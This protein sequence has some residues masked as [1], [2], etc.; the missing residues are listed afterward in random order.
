MTIKVSTV[1]VSYNRLDLLHRAIQSA[2]AQTLP[3]CEVIVV[4][5]CSSF[6]VYEAMARYGSA[7]QVV[8]TPHNAGC[9]FARN[10]GIDHAT[11]E[12]V[13]FLDD[14]DYWRP[15]K[16]EHQVAV[17][18][19]RVMMLCGQEFTPVRKYNVQP[20]SQVTRE[21]IG[22]NN[23]LCGASGFLCR[24]DLLNTIRF[25]A[26]LIWGED[27]DL[28]LR[29]LAVG[30]IGYVAEPLVFYTVNTTGT[31]L[32]S[33]TRNRSWQEIQYR[34]A[35]A[36]KHR[37]EIGEWNYRQRVADTILAH[38]MERP[39]RLSFIGHSIRKAGMTATATVLAS[40]TIA[41]MKSR[42]LQQKAK[43]LM[44]NG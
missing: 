12:F 19:D 8:R 7:V 6:D 44:Q 9:S 3:D 23:S 17:I 40:K 22:R 5:D 26:S 18:G 37:H 35:V 32:T 39:D 38:I 15:E 27:W 21:M 10:L 24:R 30:G 33:A 20:I 11:G 29:A 28:L 34:F 41:K 4:D 42:L 31:S 14:D 25:D 36:D 13:A 1:I 16:L 2:L 43:S